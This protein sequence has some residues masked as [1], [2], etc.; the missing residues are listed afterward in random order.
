VPNSDQPARVLVRRLLKDP[1]VVCR[2]LRTADNAHNLSAAFL[3][4]VVGRY[5]GTE[6]GRQELDGEVLED[7]E[8]ALWRRAWI[9]DNRK[10]ALI[11]PLR[12][13]VV[14]LDPADG[15]KDG[16]E[17]AICVAQVDLN[18]ELYVV[19]SDGYRET[20]MAWLRRAVRLAAEMKAQIIVEKNHGG[21]YL[22]GLLER[23]MVEIGVRAPYR[24]ISASQGKRTRAE[25]VAGLYEQG[26]VHHL[27][28]FPELEDQFCTWDGTGASPDR[29]DA[30]AWAITELMG[31]ARSAGVEPTVHRYTDAPVAGVHRWRDA[32]TERVHRYSPGLDGA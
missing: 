25:P 30:C 12:R 1:A 22:T 28:T 23:V 7:A 10:S 15:L 19:R 31:Y 2:R 21:A 24:V 17:Q 5:Q 18:G 9:E 20:P 13:T 27:G 16:D 3:E 8:G 29:M 6:L 26:K 4:T 14:G 11:A 32:E